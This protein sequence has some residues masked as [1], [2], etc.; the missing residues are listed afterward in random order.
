[1]A[2]PA[3]IPVV[4]LVTSDSDRYVLASV[5]GQDSLEVRFAESCEEAYTVANRM[6]APVILLDRDL[7]GTEWKTAV[8]SLADS[9]HGP[10]VILMSGVVDDYLRQELI[11]RGG[12]DVLPKPLRADQ[13]TPLVKLALSYWTSAPKPAVQA[14]R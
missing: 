11:R 9:P 3:R 7:L 12:Y 4:A 14:R 5:S 8:K 6:A 1:M 10:C 2:T 13:V